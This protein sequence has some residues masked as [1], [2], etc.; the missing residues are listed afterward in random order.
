MIPRLFMR[1]MMAH[2]LHL[3]GVGE[4]VSQIWGLTV[5]SQESGDLHT[6]AA[7]FTM[8]GN[9]CSVKKIKYS[10]K[11]KGNSQGKTRGPMVRHEK[12]WA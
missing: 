12:G 2:V 5:H 4:Y 10:T 7:T 11:K 1:A 3:S 8:W 6:L 9:Q